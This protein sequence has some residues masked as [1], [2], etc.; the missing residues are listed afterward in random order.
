LSDEKP[1][2]FFGLLGRK[3]LCDFLSPAAI[4]RT[5]AEYRRGLE[6]EMRSRAELTRARAQE[7]QAIA[8]AARNP[9]TE[10]AGS[11]V[12]KSDVWRGARLDGTVNEG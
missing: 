12:A 9:E 3:G 8:G 1:G 7:R 2:E 5:K 10:R 11:A 6:Q 4:E